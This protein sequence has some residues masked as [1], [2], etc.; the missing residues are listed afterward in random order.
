MG[1]I[2]ISAKV[3]PHI[4]APVGI[5]GN[6]F[7]AR[8]VCEALFTKPQAWTGSTGHFPGCSL[9]PGD[10]FTS[11]LSRVLQNLGLMTPAGVRAVGE[12]RAVENK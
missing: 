9:I 11:K 6:N 8:I 12:A 4:I 3:V 2:V 7:A 1:T 10:G 5:F